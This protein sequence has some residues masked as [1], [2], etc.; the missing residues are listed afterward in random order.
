VPA[1][2]GGVTVTSVPRNKPAAPQPGYN[3]VPGHF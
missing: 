1:S 3:P 2:G